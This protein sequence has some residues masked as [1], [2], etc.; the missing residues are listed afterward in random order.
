[1]V[2][3]P[4]L[5]VSP[6]DLSSD[7]SEAKIHQIYFAQQKSGQSAPH[8]VGEQEGAHPTFGGGGGGGYITGGGGINTGG[9]GGG[10]TTTGGGGG[11]GK[12]AWQHDGVQPGA[13]D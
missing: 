11:G 9:G 7:N 3:C 10:I 4:S 12:L 5:F 2:N 6:S 8:D 1:M 13:Q